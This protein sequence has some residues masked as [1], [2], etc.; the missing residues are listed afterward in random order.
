M[1]HP[2]SSPHSAESGPFYCADCNARMVDDDGA[3]DL[4]PV[5]DV[6]PRGQCGNGFP[7]SGYDGKPC[8]LNIK[9]A[10]DLG[11]GQ[12]VT[13]WDVEVGEPDA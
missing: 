9:D 3:G 12:V 8:V 10:T 13:T 4:C 7:C 5:C 1:S 11:A 2:E 6:H